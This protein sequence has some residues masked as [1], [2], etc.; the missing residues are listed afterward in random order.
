MD[1][2]LHGALG[3]GGRQVRATCWVGRSFF[4][5]RCRLTTSRIV[6]TRAEFHRAVN[7][8]IAGLLIRNRLG[9]DVFGT[10]TR[11]EQV[12]L[13]DFQTGDI[14]ELDF[15]FDCRLTRQEY[16]LTVATQHADGSSQD[17]LDDVVSFSVADSRDVAGVADL[18]VKIGIRRP[19]SGHSDGV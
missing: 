5:G 18:G 15:Q 7:D 1:H 8:P 14:L 2:I 4:G 9:I 13:G 17:W 10:N 19:N 6:R 11:I 16:T 3:R 12:P